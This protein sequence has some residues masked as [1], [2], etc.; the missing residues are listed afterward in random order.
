MASSEYRFCDICNNIHVTTYATVCCPECDENFCKKCKTHHDVANATKKHET[1]SIENAL[2]LPKCVQEIKYNCTDHNER[3]VYFCYTHERPCC[4]EC[5]KDK[6]HSGFCCFVNV[7][8]AVKDVKQS[9]SFLDLQTTLSDLLTNLSSII[10]HLGANL[11]EL[12]KQKVTCADE[13]RSTR[14]AINSYLDQ[15][16]KDLSNEM[17]ETFTSKE[18]ELQYLLEELELRKTRVN[19]MHASVNVIRDAASNFQTFMSIPEYINTAHSEEI[20]LQSLCENESLNW[21]SISVNPTSIQAIKD[22]LTSFGTMCI[23]RKAPNLSIKVQKCRQAQLTPTGFLS[24]TIETMEFKEVYQNQ[25]QDGYYILD[26]GILPNGELLFSDRRK[27]CLVKYDTR[28]AF[29]QIDLPF[30]PVRFA[31]VNENNI[32]VT[33][34]KELH[35]V[36][37]DDYIILNLKT[38]HFKKESLLGSVIIYDNNYIIEDLTGYRIIDSEGNFIQHI[39]IRFDESAYR[40]P[41]CFDNKIYLVDYKSSKIFSYDFDGNKIWEFQNEKLMS[42]YGLTSNNSNI[43]FACGYR[44]NNVCALSADGKTFKEIIGPK[45]ELKCSTAVHYS[46]KRKE[47]LVVTSYGNIFVFA[48]K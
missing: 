40:E 5:L 29:V 46:V 14:E 25:I 13:I 23:K 44:S 30:F 48:D 1:I 9:P 6:L 27:K 33:S 24:N 45:T 26:C 19:E 38:F 15:L 3:F 20:A 21:N 18:L 42:P 28:S 2:K 37:L 39:P 43:L 31:I 11:L 34:E 4:I 17:Q 32:A 47:L 7:D 8:T 36:K 12:A 16:E 22:N 35:I 41:V 10:E